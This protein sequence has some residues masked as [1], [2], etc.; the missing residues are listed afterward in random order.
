MQLSPCVICR[1]PA[2]PTMA[3]A[4]FR[5]F[6]ELKAAEGTRICRYCFREIVPFRIIDLS[7]IVVQWE[8]FGAPGDYNTTVRLGF[9]EW[10]CSCEGFKH[11]HFCYHIRRLF[12]DEGTNRI[13]EKA[14]QDKQV[15]FAPGPQD[16]GKGESPIDLVPQDIC[17]GCPEVRAW[18]NCKGPCPK[19]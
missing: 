4:A 14:W 8:R 19:K 12:K 13:P 10:R 18:P 2:A 1:D 17:A 3:L 7:P 6:S 9:K 15:G 5:S 11:S 16:P